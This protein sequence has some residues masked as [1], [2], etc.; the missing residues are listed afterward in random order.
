MGRLLHHARLGR[1]RPAVRVVGAGCVLAVAMAVGVAEEGTPLNVAPATAAQHLADAHTAQQAGRWHEAADHYR[2]ALALDPASVAAREGLRAADE[3]LAG[4]ADATHTGAG[5]DDVRRQ[6]ALVEA[7]SALERADLLTRTGRYAEAEAALI[8][9]RENLQ[10]VDDKASLAND[11]ARVETLLR[12]VQVGQDQQHGTGDAAG[13]AAA[14]VTA[15][16]ATAAAVAHESNELS[17][18]LARIRV[19][20]ARQHHALALEAARRLVT[21]MPG[22]AEAELV[23]NEALAAA[24]AQ[25]AHDIAE[26][27]VELKKEVLARIHD[28]LIPSGFDGLPIYP[29]NWTDRHQGRIEIGTES[30][31]YEP[32]HEDL[33]NRLAGR[34]TVDFDNLAVE[35]AL[36]FLAKVGSFNLV[37]DPAVFAA[38]GKVVTL[39]ATDMRIDTVLIWLGRLTGSTWIMSKGAVYFGGDQTEE[40][41]LGVYD[42]AHL[43][44]APYDQSGWNVAFNS[45]SGAG[46]T[47]GGLNIFEQDDAPVD[48][49]APEDVVDL[50]RNA[51]SPGKWDTPEQTLEIRSNVLYVTAS[52]STHQL[53]QEFLRSQAYARSLVVHVTCRWL[54]INDTYLEQIGVDW[55]SAQSLLNVNGGVPQGYADN[56]ANAVWGGNV[57]NVL[58]ATGV[59]AAANL[60]TTGLNLSMLRLGEPQWSAILKAVEQKNQGRILASPEVTTLNGV[61]GNAFFGQQ[62]AYIADYEVVNNNLDPTISVLTV[63]A[64]LDIK[65]FI[66]ADRKYVTMEF[67][68]G[69]A[70]VTFFTELISAPR[71]IGT[72]DGGGV[73]T[74]PVPY[75]IELPNVAIEEV[76]TTIIVPD[77]GILMVGGFNRAIDQQTS[78]K[79][80][81]LGHIPYLGRLFGTR[82]RFSERLRLYLLAAVDIIDYREA[83]ENL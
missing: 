47:G 49:I 7:R 55:G 40:P 41:V 23:F 51:V 42:L 65:P 15:E 73:V 69:L 75:P 39:R 78:A 33:L 63:G 28:S 60:A 82:G 14:L 1:S 56:N 66:S 74:P 72:G 4:R 70:S 19:L 32:W 52:R 31:A 79:V 30:T 16:H 38:G 64:T 36:A 34:V 12:E 26:S 62:H 83:E 81:F 11:L 6:L 35:E 61:R 25:R 10:N 37:V 45:S 46:G 24:H 20:L 71:V 22:N 68:P 29:P 21:A 8:R 67:R 9:A 59:N 76:S 17:E 3:V 57:L 2:L 58:P 48:R 43:V 50:I 44:S 27:G 80:P 54:T 5:R 53:L 18:R 77:K 13:R